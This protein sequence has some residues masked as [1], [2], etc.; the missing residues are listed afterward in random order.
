MRAAEPVAVAILHTEDVDRWIDAAT[1]LAEPNAVHLAHI[2]DVDVELE[3]ARFARSEKRRA[4]SAHVGAWNVGIAVVGQRPTTDRRAGRIYVCAPAD[5]GHELLPLAVALTLASRIAGIGL[6]ADDIARLNSAT[7]GLAIDRPAPQ[8]FPDRRRIVEHV[9]CSD[10][11][12]LRRIT[13]AMPALAPSAILHLD[14]IDLESESRYEQLHFTDQV[15]STVARGSRL[16]WPLCLIEAGTLIEHS[17]DP[18]MTTP[19]SVVVSAHQNSSIV[20]IDYDADTVD[21]A[22]LRE[23]TQSLRSQIPDSNSDD[24]VRSLAERIREQVEEGGDNVAAIAY[25]ENGTTTELTYRDLD[26]RS[27]VLAA[28][29]VRCGFGRGSIIGIALGRGIDAVVATV[30]VLR[31]GGTYLP[32]DPSYPQDRVAFMSADSG[33]EVVI[34]A[35]E[36]SE[37][38][39]RRIDVGIAAQPGAEHTPWV[40]TSADDTVYVLYTSGSTGTPK[41]VAHTIA[42]ISNLVD[43]HIATSTAERDRRVLQFASLNFD[44]AAQEILTALS[45]GKTLVIP[46]ETQRT[47][48][49][50]LVE[51]IREAGVTEFFCPQVLL[52]EV[53]RT[54]VRERHTVPLLRHVFQSGEA[55]VMNEWIDR[56]FHA[57]PRATLHN[58]YGPTETHVITALALPRRSVARGP[59]AL[60]PTISGADVRV[61]SED[62]TPVPDDEIGELYPTQGQLARGYL[63]R[64][65]LTAARFVAD[66][67]GAPGA[68]MY[69]SGDIVRRSSAGSLSYVGRSDDQV[70]IR[71]HRVEPDEVS[72]R[73]LEFPEVRGAATVVRRIEGGTAALVSFVVVETGVHFDGERMRGE[74]E[75]MLPSYLVP[76][77]VRSIDRLPL[78]PSGKVAKSDL[79]A[80]CDDYRA[81]GSVSS[82]YTSYAAEMLSGCWTLVTGRSDFTSDSD[83]FD[84]GGNSLSVIR[85]TAEVHDRFSV[86]MGVADIHGNPRF[87]D[88]LALIEARMADSVIARPELPLRIVRDLQS[89]YEPFELLD[90]QQAYLIGRGSDLTGGNV[91]C[92]LYMEF[93]GRRDDFDIARAQE[94]LRRTIDTHDMLRVVFDETG[95]S[96]RVLAHVEPYVIEVFDGTDPA[97]E[98]AESVRRRLSHEACPADRFPLFTVTAI[99]LPEKMTRLC[100]SIDSLLADARSVQIFFDAWSDAYAG[101]EIAS[102]EVSFR[103]YVRTMSK[104]PSTSAFREAKQY[105]LDRVDS[106]PAAPALPMTVDPVAASETVPEFVSRRHVMSAPQWERLCRFGRQRGL[107]PTGILATA[108]ASVL[109]QWSDESRFL[110]NIPTGNRFPFD[111]HVQGIVGEFASFELLEVDIS[112]ENSFEK[113]AIELQERLTRDLDH[114]HFSGMEVVRELIRHRGGLAGPIAPVVLTSELGVG[115]G[116]DAIFGGV[117]RESYTVSQTPQVWMD[118]LVHEREGAL[119][120]NWDVVESMFPDGMVEDMFGLLV[121]QVERL[122]LAEHEW[123]SLPVSAVSPADADNRGADVARPA[124]HLAPHVMIDCWARREPKAVAFIDGDDAITRGQLAAQVHDVA[125]RIRKATAESDVDASTAG[126]VAVLAEKGWRQYAGCLAAMHAGYAY[127][128]IDVNQPMVRIERILS[129]VG[130]R[131]VLIDRS[132]REVPV[133]A[134]TVLLDGEI[135]LSFDESVTQHRTHDPASW[136]YVLFTSGSTGEPKG[137]PITIAGLTACVT[138]TIERFAI[139]AADR[140]LAVS[141]VHHDMSLFDV[142]VMLAAGGSV[143]IP[144]AG[145]ADPVQWADLVVRH[146]VSTWCSVP[147]MVEMV[148][149]GARVLGRKLPLRLVLTGGD[150]IPLPLIEHLREQAPDAEMVSIG[151]PTE[152]TGWNIFFRIPPEG[153]VPPGWSSVPYGAAMAG[154]H[155]RVVDNAGRDRPDWAAGELVVEG[156]GV[157]PGYITGIDDDRRREDRRTGVVHFRTGD[158]GRFRPDGLIEFLGRWDDTIKLRGHRIHPGEVES[159]IESFPGVRKAA[160]LVVGTVLH[161]LIEVAVDGKV[162]CRIRTETGPVSALD[163]TALRSHLEA[164]LPAHMVPSSMTFTDALPLTRNGKVDRGSVRDMVSANAVRSQ[165]DGVAELADA[166]PLDRL[167]CKIWSDC[168]VTVDVPKIEAVPSDNFFALGGDSLVASRIVLVLREIFYEA[169]F[170]VGIVFASESAADCAVR[171]RN[172]EPMPGRFDEIASWYLEIDA[173]GDVE[174]EQYLSADVDAEE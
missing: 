78:T 109:A 80:L 63:G 112:G 135:D 83:F 99:D 34:T 114:R 9:E 161:G 48:P 144:S 29:L 111:E 119:V 91:A 168:I 100:V 70:K 148:L 39:C 96:Q 157:T 104:L 89:R 1:A 167:V 106:L 146:Q 92:H 125:S 46:T 107:T 172:L 82:R 5:G 24:G 166:A 140:S 53:C 130:T 44:V 162:D 134:P 38:Y 47:D 145:A 20:S 25:C 147:A 108:Y 41:A 17:H 122:A 126:V 123:S 26:G 51:L 129:T 150:W 15:G 128:P 127:L 6:W 154:A 120:M 60:G 136:A 142:F 115:R 84:V 116:V 12:I 113:A 49:T 139:S 30:A 28:E 56:F 73:L 67:Y 110:L 2:G 153:T 163:A 52:Q 138:D 171:L 75:K 86:R 105:W 143:V 164:R 76:D 7:G 79:V 77:S 158:R 64:P 4:A 71:G 133:D 66:P 102:P 74:L 159:A 62:L 19:V 40:K 87:A 137:V 95:P 32:L 59:V 10:V 65:G 8:T 94:S 3:M 131:C 61:L 43:W 21:P 72:T 23:F 11:E 13:R 97:L 57:N 35:D 58:H 170:G 101:R 31:V 98:V 155:Y 132:D 173:M 18:S 103:D 165:R 37:K 27:A 36:G 152:T 33:V 160:A 42:A 81:P 14:D 169:V 174:L 117:L 88:Q 90:Q 68:R 149:S 22:S 124:A 156:P 85:L 121:E 141:A 118:L 55:L 93:D 50:L 54:A 151:G 16:L 69:R 45:G